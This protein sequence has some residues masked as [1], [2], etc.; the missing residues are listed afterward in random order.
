MTTRMPFGQ[1]RG[2]PIT[3]LPPSY[4]LWLLDNI[5]GQPSLL[6]KVWTVLADY[7]EGH[8]AATGTI[9]GGQTPPCSQNYEAII[10]AWHREQSL[11]HHPD[12]GGNIEVMTALN[13]LADSLRAALE[14]A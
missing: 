7:L 9:H 1:F 14:V 4:L 5:H 6:A 12:H 10:R 11:K 2:Q 3:K 8:D 13:H